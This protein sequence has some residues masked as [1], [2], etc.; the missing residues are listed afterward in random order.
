M[1]IT[2]LLLLPADAILLFLPQ[3]AAAARYASLLMLFAIFI[4]RAMRAAAI[5]CRHNTPPLLFSF[6]PADAAAMPAAAAFR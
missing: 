3:Y 4:A 6:S 5:R 1:L 2:L